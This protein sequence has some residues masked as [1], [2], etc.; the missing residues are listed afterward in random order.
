MGSSMVDTVT[1]EDIRYDLE[2]Q[3]KYLAQT[4]GFNETDMAM[5]LAEK[6]AVV[7]RAHGAWRAMRNL[8]WRL[9]NPKHLGVVCTG[10]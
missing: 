2:L 8:L 5:H 7:D 6:G 9:D 4:Y 1:V 10:G 3:I